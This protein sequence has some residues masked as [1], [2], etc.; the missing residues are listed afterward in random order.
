LAAV[1][2]QAYTWDNNGNLLATGVSTNTWDAANRLIETGRNGNVLQF[3]AAFYLGS[4]TRAGPDNT[5]RMERECAASPPGGLRTPFFIRCL[6]Y[7]PTT[8]TLTASE[9]RP[10]TSSGQGSLSAPGPRYK[11]S[12]SSFPR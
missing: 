4:A 9:H 5:Q 6:A 10:S 7:T 1:N 12:L 11:P 8:C 2:G 3:V